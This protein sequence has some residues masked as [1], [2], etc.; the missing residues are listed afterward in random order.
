[1]ARFFQARSIHPPEVEGQLGGGRPVDAAEPCEVTPGRDTDL[2]GDF[3]VPSGLRSVLP[4]GP[5]GT[6]QPAPCCGLGD[7]ESEAL[8]EHS[9][10]GSERVGGYPS[11]HC[12]SHPT[13]NNTQGKPR[14]PQ[15]VDKEHGKWW[16]T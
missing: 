13:S 4:G 3:F 1:M 15:G 14:S 10:A 7:V 16:L 2:V 12:N 9:E 6:G 11:F 8:A 5:T